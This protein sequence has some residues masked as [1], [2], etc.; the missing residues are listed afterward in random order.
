MGAFAVYIAHTVHIL[1][2]NAHVMYYAVI[3][4]CQMSGYFD[5]CEPGMA[6]NLCFWALILFDIYFRLWRYPDRT[7]ANNAANRTLGRC[8]KPRK[9]ATLP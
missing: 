6:I 7:F 1:Q 2:M 8:P 5:V 4:S 9:G 3:V